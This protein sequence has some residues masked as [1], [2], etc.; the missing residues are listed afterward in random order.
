MI[1]KIHA[2][3]KDAYKAQDM[4][5]KDFLG[6]LI[7]EVT[8]A[9]KTPSDQDVIAKI[10]SMLKNNQTSFE[11]TGVSSLN[12]SELDILNSYLPKQM[13]DSEID[14]IIDNAILSG[15]SNIGQIMG[16]FKGMEVDMCVLWFVQW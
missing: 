4:P 16:A 8:R 14:S 2:Q 15:A 9:S 12:D 5:R 7:G 13:S 10:K 3:F 1:N 6:V 11:L